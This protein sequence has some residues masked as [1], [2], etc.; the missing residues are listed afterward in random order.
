MKRICGISHWI[1]LRWHTILY[2]VVILL[3]NCRLNARIIETSK[4]KWEYQLF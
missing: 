3:A 1:R 4:T 2:M